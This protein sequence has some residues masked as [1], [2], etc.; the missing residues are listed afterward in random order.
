MHEYP[1][2]LANIPTT[3][4]AGMSLAVLGAAFRADE[5]VGHLWHRHELWQVDAPGIDIEVPLRPARAAMDLQQPPLPDQI[6]D[7][8]RL[9]PEPL[10]L[11]PAP[12]L[13]PVLL[14][15]HKLRKLAISLEI[16]RASSEVRRFADDARAFGGS[17]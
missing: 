7:R 13:V 5:V 10:G 14:E 1:V 9:E 11:A 15:L 2:P 4:R 8:H 3:P 17:P 12:G 16:R 6:A